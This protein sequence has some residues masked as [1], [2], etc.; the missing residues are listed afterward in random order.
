M[1]YS[2]L[3]SILIFISCESNDEHPCDADGDGCPDY[4]DAFPN[5][6]NYSTDTDKDGLADNDPEELDIDGDNLLDG[7]NIDLWHL[8][9]DALSENTGHDYSQDSIYNTCPD[10]EVLFDLSGSEDSDG[11]GC[12][13]LFDHYPDNE[14]RETNTSLE[15]SGSCED[16]MNDCDGKFEEFTNI[17]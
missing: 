13:D 8:F 3:I 4:Y 14:E 1:K 15:G 17:K 10:A 6:N 11:D 12:N 5:D 16:R 7:T 2:L 9:W